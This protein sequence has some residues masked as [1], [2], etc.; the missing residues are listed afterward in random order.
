MP[1]TGDCQG[2]V[3]VIDFVKFH[4]GSVSGNNLEVRM[5]RV[6]KIV[7]ALL[8]VSAAAWAQSSA[9]ITGSV[10]DATG[11]AVPGA[12]IKATQTATGAVRTVTSG[13]DGGYVLAN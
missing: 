11:A 12:E 3:H 13:A 7:T 1:S 5:N 2:L 8:L 6:T 10:K 9:Q 4:P